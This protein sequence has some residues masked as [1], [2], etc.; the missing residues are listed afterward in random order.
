MTPNETLSNASSLEGY[1]AFGRA[2]EL[3]EE[4]ELNEAEAL[5]TELVSAGEYREESQALLGI[6]LFKTDRTAEAV[7]CFTNLVIKQPGSES[8]SLGLFH[9]LWKAEKIDEAF[10]E[11]RRYRAEHESM[12]YQRLLRDLKAEGIVPP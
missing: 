6:I 10:A 4:G 7:A 3:L 5:L 2:T 12:E 1:E 9:A 8:A 11:M